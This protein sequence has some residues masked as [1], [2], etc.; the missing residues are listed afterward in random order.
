M[1]W[2][3]SQEINIVSLDSSLNHGISVYKVSKKYLLNDSCEGR[4]EIDW[5]LEW[6]NLNIL[7][8]LKESC[9]WRKSLKDNRKK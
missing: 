7:I 5:Y 4:R 3:D 2:M 8:R 9:Q 6:K 1:Q